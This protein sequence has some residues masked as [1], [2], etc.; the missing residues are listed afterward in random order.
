LLLAYLR[1]F[2]AERWSDVDEVLA[3]GRDI[4]TLQ[5]STGAPV[6]ARARD[7]G[8]H[9]AALTRLGL[10][11]FWSGDLDG[12]E[13]RLYEAQL[14]AAASGFDQAHLQSMSHLALLA[15]ARG[16]LRTA[17]E[18]SQTGLALAHQH[19]LADRHHA[20]GIHLALALVFT[21]WNDLASAERH[22]ERALATSSSFPWQP[23]KIGAALAHAWLSKGLERHDKGIAILNGI[24]HKLGAVTVPPWLERW[25]DVT[26]AELSITSG[27]L[28]TATSL[29]DDLHEEDLP[30]TPWSA[31]VA[32][33]LG[34]L[35]LARGEPAATIDTTARY[36]EAAT[37]TL[38]GPY[39]SAWLV[40]AVAADALDDHQLA[41]RALKT[42]LGLAEPE[43]FRQRFTAAPVRRLLAAHFDHATAF[44]PFITELLN[45]HPVRPTGTPAASTLIEA[46]TDRERV[47]L[48]YLPSRLSAEEIAAEL[49]LSMHTVKTHIRHIYRKIQVHG[50][51]E[52]VE[53]ARARGLL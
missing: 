38:P 36:L 47:I 5:A 40:T 52:A 13:A 20:S 29:L 46:L 39:I 48:R 7:N 6:V 28:T 42:A 43:R 17:F 3:A 14:R 41:A 9:A 22:I 12:A 51:R 23:L 34:E 2:I 21:E 11:E 30:A 25:I 19:A 44:R 50:R 15:V 18:T 53:H 49:H 16:R 4:V 37:S 45:A 31:P 33:A 8:I 10:A 35:Q 1:L 26:E 32:V 24:R 27:D